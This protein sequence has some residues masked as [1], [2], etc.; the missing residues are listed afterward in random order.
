MAMNQRER[1]LAIGVGVVAGVFGLQYGFNSIRGKLDAKQQQIE[2][3]EKK[4]FDLTKELNSGVTAK[5]R[6]N[7]LALKSLPSKSE[8]AI[9]QYKAWLTTTGR[10][11]GFEGINVS[12]QGRPRPTDAFKAYKFQLKGSCDT[13]Q[14]LDFLGM[15]YD[16]D[17]LH[18]I[19]IF[20]MTPSPKERDQFTVTV[21]AEVLSLN[22]AAKDQAPTGEPSGR[23][24][25]T[26]E[27]YKQSVLKRNP[28]SPPNE[29]PRITSGTIEFTLG[30]SGSETLKA[31]DEEGHSVD[32]NLISTDLPKGL[33]MKGGRLS[34][35]PSEIGK[36]KI[37]VEA[38]DDGWPNMSSKKDITVVVK[39]PQKPV[40]KA[41]PEKFDPATQTFIS[42]I[43][44]GSR[45]PQ[46]WIRSRTDNKLFKKYSGEEIEIGTIKA[47]VV[48]I[49]PREE[50]VEFESEGAHWIGGM[51][52]SL[53]DAYQKSMED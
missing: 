33:Q 11:A 45:G 3:A 38:V 26:L 4:S 34:G 20:K 19:R 51:N 48:S 44:S 32:F 39:E 50:Y 47:T 13:E 35:T 53:A 40:V 21:D 8:T 18:S 41:E 24:A 52:K 37:E 16:K 43:V 49:N 23:L 29:P 1:F 14:A 5:R 27:E 6:L 36:T 7:A 2:S 22:A 12:P 15:F 17:Y 25:M 9:A 46:A 30:E 42:G 31:T 10:E 28:F